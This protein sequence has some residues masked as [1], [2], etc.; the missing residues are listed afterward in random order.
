MVTYARLSVAAN[1]CR[2]LKEDFP[3]A[4]TDPLQRSAMTDQRN[5]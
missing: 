4:L 3:P 2:F 5:K 1:V